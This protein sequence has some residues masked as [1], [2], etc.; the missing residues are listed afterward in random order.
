MKRVFR[1][2]LFAL[3]LIVGQV[4]GGRFIIPLLR[5][6]NLSIPQLLVVNQIIFLII[7]SLIYFLITGLPIKETLR[8][9]KLKGDEIFKIILIALLSQPVAWFLSFLSSLFFNN[10]VAEVFKAMQGI[11]YVSMLIVM[12]LTPAICE[13]I[14][15]RGIVLSGYDNKSNFKAAMMSGLIFGMLHLNGQQ[16]LYAFVLGILFGYLV[17]ITNSI[18]ATMLCH[19]TF[20]GI[21]V[22]MQYFLVKVLGKIGASTTAADARNI[23]LSEKLNTLIVLFF[24]AAIFAAII[25]V[26]VKGMYNNRIKRNEA[27]EINNERLIEDSNDYIFNI[28]FVIT[29]I[30]YIFF[31][32]R[33]A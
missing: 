19:F 8:L 1:S 3:I 13:E 10:D 23:P 20:N 18:F 27:Y 5:G 30:F 22:T 17:R 28:P 21:Q 24:I 4:F 15:M 26:V 32:A 14:T 16:F 29:V 7:P 11:S 9:N 33:I 25:F 2:N 6:F 31:I 12:A